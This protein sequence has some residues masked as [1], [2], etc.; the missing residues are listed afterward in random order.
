VIQDPLR[1]L[2]GQ[3]IIIQN[4]G[5]AGGNI[6]IGAVARARPDGY[7]LLMAASNFAVNPS[8]YATTP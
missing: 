3:P 7:T 6:G 8:L 5:G 2:L 1:Q 4:R